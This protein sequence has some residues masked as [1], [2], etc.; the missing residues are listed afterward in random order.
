MADSLANTTN[1]STLSLEKLL[2][3]YRNL[4]EAKEKLEDCY[5]KVAE[6]VGDDDDTRKTFEGRLEKLNG[7][8]DAQASRLRNI[9]DQSPGQPTTGGRSGR[10]AT[11]AKPTHRRLP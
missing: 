8:Y 11:A 2:K 4:D 9:M 7:D 1:L 5:L 6:L 10:T 3:S